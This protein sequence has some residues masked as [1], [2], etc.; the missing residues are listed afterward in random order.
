ML[1]YTLHIS[2]HN[3]A[4]PYVPWS[5]WCRVTSPPGICGN[6]RRHVDRQEG[7][8]LAQLFEMAGGLNRC[9]QK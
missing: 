7:V 3:K 9:F 2:S 1:I 8:Q 5:L 4:I 6:F